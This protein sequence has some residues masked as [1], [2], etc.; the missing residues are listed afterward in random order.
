M[1]SEELKYTIKLFRNKYCRNVCEI[2]ELEDIKELHNE[3]TMAQVITGDLHDKKYILY[4]H[5]DLVYSN[6][7]YM[8]QILF[9]EFTHISDS[10]QFLNYNIVKF[11]D[12]MQIYSEIH[13]SEIQMNVMLSYSKSNVY[14]LNQDV[15]FNKGMLKLQSFMKQSL[16]HA[17]REFSSYGSNDILNTY[18]FIGYLNSLKKHGI[19]FKYKYENIRP[20]LIESFQLIT[21]SIL[22]N[23][24]TYN[25]LLKTHR[26]LLTLVQKPIP[27]NVDSIINKLIDW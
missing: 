25:K 11:K 21:N 22:N 13:A 7:N 2:P 16:D 8:E 6:A 17:M 19:E 20:E 24:Y 14:N 15:I 5:S 3:N 26:Y 1:L 4:I 27:V 12:I 9:H 10:I 18:Y 23:T